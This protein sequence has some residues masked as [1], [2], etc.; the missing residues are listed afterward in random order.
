MEPLTT[1]VTSVMPSAASAAT[2]AC[3]CHVSRSGQI[4]F[5]LLSCRGQASWGLPVEPRAE[6]IG[7]YRTAVVL[8]RYRPATRPTSRWVAGSGVQ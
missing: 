4:L 3:T 8:H 1:A 6:H 7:S 2:S 5:L